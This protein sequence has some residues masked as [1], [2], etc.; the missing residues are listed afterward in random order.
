MK[1]IL[2]LLAGILC[3][4]GCNQKPAVLQAGTVSRDTI[5]GTPCMV[6]VPYQY[7]ARAAKGEIF[8]VLYLV[9]SIGSSR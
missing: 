4:A 5:Q 2:L 8:P 1:K 9:R 3:L 7:A 6:Y